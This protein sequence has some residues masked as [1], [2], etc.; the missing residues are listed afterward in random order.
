MVDI[1]KKLDLAVKAYLK[2]QDRRWDGGDCIGLIER[3]DENCA[4]LKSLD[5]E[6][7]LFPAPPDTFVPSEALYS[8]IQ[9]QPPKNDSG[10]FAKNL[11]DLLARPSYLHDSPASFYIAD[12]GQSYPSDGVVC[13]EVRRYLDT[14]SLVQILRSFADYFDYSTGSLRLVFLQKTKL[15]IIVKYNVE[16]LFELDKIDEFKIIFEENVHV[17]QRRTIFKQ[18]LID[19]LSDLNCEECFSEAIKKFSFIYG[20]FLDNYKLYVSDFSFDK[21]YKEIS[22]KKLEYILKINKNLSEIQNQLLTVPLAALLVGSQMTSG[23]NVKNL[24]I[25]LS[26][27]IFAFFISL[28]L[29]NQR[30]S[31]D[32][33]NQEI[34]SQKEQLKYEHQ[35]LDDRFDHIFSDL[36]DRYVKHRRI[37]TYIDFAV[38]FI[39]VVIP[40]A[41]FYIFSIK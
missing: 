39:V 38:S 41:L 24:T 23:S 1:N 3:T 35:A 16:D 10:F 21:I 4:L 28:L 31:L 13:S 30:R 14:I 37:L 40:T 19:V 6:G 9:L 22:D 29:R 18:V 2:M 15:E 11:E 32:A 36:S 12:L 5:D 17:E 33:I 8:E 26:A 20:K 7:L 34:I 25:Y 27:I